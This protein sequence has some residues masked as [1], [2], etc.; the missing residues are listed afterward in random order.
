MQELLL[1]GVLLLVDR[2]PLRCCAAGAAAQLVYLR[3]LQQPRFPLIP[4]LSADFVAAASAF[5]A[6]QRPFAAAATAAAAAAAH[7][8]RRRPPAAGCAAWLWGMHLYYGTSMSLEAAAGFL[9]AT[10]L[11]VPFGLVVSLSATES[12]LPSASSA[13]RGPPAREA[14]A[15]AVGWGTRGAAGGSDLHA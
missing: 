2:Q 13:I 11:V 3:L 5:C 8:G 1:H 12:T 14:P 6:S 15:P 10:T 4:L 9:T 7:R